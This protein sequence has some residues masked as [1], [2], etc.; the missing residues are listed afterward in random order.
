MFDPSSG[1]F[2]SAG[3]L[4][5]KRHK[6][7]ATLLADG[8]VLIAGG[9]DERDGRAGSAYRNVEIFNPT[10]GRFTSAGNMNEGRY[11]LQGTTVLLRDGKVLIAGGSDRVEV[12]D[13]ATGA[14][15]LTRGDMGTT[16]LFATATLLNNGQVLIIGG[17]N[18]SQAVSSNA[19]IYRS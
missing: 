9:T 15:S 7:D 13:P 4:T 5:L 16:R 19:W 6:H 14:F 8:R 1:T 17:Y 10:N 18:D 11:K 12:F 2:T 3:S